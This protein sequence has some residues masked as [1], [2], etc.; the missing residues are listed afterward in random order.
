MAMPTYFLYRH[1]RND[2]SVPFYIGIGKKREQYKFQ[3]RFIYGRAYTT[4]KRN[5]LWNEVVSQTDYDIEILYECNNRQDIGK[6]EIEFIALYGRIHN[7]TGTLTNMNIGGVICNTLEEASRRKLGRAAFAYKHTGEFYKEFYSQRQAAKEL[8]IM[9]AVNVGK[10]INSGGVFKGYI[11]YDKYMGDTVPPQKYVKHGGREICV[12][13]LVTKR[14]VKEY[15]SMTE[16]KKDTGICQS[17]AYAIL[18][19]G[20]SVKGKKYIFKDNLPNEYK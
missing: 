15:A 4:E 5:D 19:N 8:G 20:L 10:S 2:T 16:Y 3:D 1:I 9:E 18:N 11:F 6:K 7:G 12:I 17:T 14:V 13:D